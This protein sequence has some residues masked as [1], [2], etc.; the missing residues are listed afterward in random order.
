M[1][2][3]TIRGPPP[4][5]AVV[6]PATAGDGRVRLVYGTVSCRALTGKS[7]GQT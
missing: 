7:L 6:P 1:N 3:L 4:N 5:F 2:F